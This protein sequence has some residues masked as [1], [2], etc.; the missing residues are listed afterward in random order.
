MIKS[1]RPPGRHA[2]GLDR[3]DHRL[4]MLRERLLADRA[5]TGNRRE[6]EPPARMMRQGI[7]MYRPA[8]EKTGDFGPK[9]TT[10]RVVRQLTLRTLYLGV[11]KLID[12][13]SSPRGPKLLLASPSP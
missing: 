5:L 6:P 10:E 3:P 9:R 12:D 4:V 13:N 8:S 1:S 7:E 2:G 11:V